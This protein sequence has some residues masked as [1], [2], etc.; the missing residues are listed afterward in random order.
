MKENKIIKEDKQ[1]QEEILGEVFEEIVD[2]MEL[3]EED[4][5]GEENE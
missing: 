2:T 3:E 4:T 5:L 1:K